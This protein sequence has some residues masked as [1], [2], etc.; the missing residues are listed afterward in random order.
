VKI[1][2]KQ[3]QI[4]SDRKPIGNGACTR[5]VEEAGNEPRALTAR[6]KRFADCYRGYRRLTPD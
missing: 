2:R 1:E 6:Q 4:A 5:T 3:E